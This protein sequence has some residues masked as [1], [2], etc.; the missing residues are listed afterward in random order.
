VGPAPTDP[1][2]LRI[3]EFE[4]RSA[5]AEQ[6]AKRHRLVKDAERILSRAKADER[7]IL[8]PSYDQLCLGVRVSKGAL[9]RALTFINAVILLLEAEGFPVSVQSGRHGTGVLIFGHRVQFAISEKVRE[10]G[11]R[12]VKEYSWTRTIIEYQPS[13]QLDFRYGDYA[14]GR[15]HRDGK[16]QQLEAL[17]HTCVASLMREGR[18]S[19]ISAKLEEQRNIERAAKERERA[20]LASQIA[21]EEKKVKDLETWVSHWTRA[22]QMRDFIAALEK[23]WTE[24]GL[25]LSPERQAGQR[26]IW[27]RQQADR[28]DP[29]LPN[30]PSIID[31]RVELNRY[32]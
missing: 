18:A 23:V 6:D 27:M 25:N 5:S 15:K 17:L 29:M 32:W 30:P 20:E 21:D 11:R 8:Q 1:E 2:F 19:L 13:G 16:K 31:R 14:Y 10:I 28:L 3:I 7:S 22:Q 4:S 24:Q 12:E 26:I 9:T